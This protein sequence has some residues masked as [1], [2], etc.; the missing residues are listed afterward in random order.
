MKFKFLASL[1]VLMAI[2]CADSPTP[3]P[4]D[5]A[6][7]SNATGVDITIPETSEGDASATD[8]AASERLVSINVTNMH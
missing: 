5:V 2:G 6:G 7:D 4:V 8:A 1:S 3:S